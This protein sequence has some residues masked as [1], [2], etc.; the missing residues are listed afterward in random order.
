MEARYKSLAG[1]DASPWIEHFTKTAGK[2]DILSS[3][4]RAIVVETKSKSRDSHGKAVKNNDNL[5]LTIVSPVGQS[6]EMAQADLNMEV[7]KSRIDRQAASLAS[8]TTQRSQHTASKVAATKHSQ[9][10][11]KRKSTTRPNAAAGTTGK[12]SKSGK[13]L[14]RIRDIFS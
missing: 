12:K 13:S 1:M 7:D 10:G 6:T 4:P 9:R 2:T 11:K 8:T 5:P 14:A 3:R